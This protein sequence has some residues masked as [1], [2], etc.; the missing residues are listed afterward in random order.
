MTFI[1]QLWFGDRSVHVYT[2]RMEHLS[3]AEVARMDEI[4]DFQDGKLI[5]LK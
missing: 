3:P 5:R 4:F 1:G 2:Q